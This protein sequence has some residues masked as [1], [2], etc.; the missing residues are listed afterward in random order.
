VTDKE[1]INW[2]S[3]PT[4]GAFQTEKLPKKRH[5]AYSEGMNIPNDP[6]RIFLENEKELQ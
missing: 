2:T 3:S 1:N 4:R 5:K 6:K